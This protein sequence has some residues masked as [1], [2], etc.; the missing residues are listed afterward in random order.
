MS[1]SNKRVYTGTDNPI[2][3]QRMRGTAKQTYENTMASLQDT[4][5][6]YESSINENLNFEP[7]DIERFL[8]NDNNSYENKLTKDTNINWENITA[9]SLISFEGFKSEAY[10]DK[11]ISGNKDGFRV[12]YGSGT[13][14][15]NGK[16][17]KVKSGDTVTKEEAIADLNRRIGTEFGPRAAKQSG[18][19]WEGLSNNAKAALTSIVYNAGSLPKN[20]RVAIK[21]GNNAKIAE[22]I[23]ANGVGT[24]IAGRRTKEANLFLKPDSANSLVTRRNK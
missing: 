11:S 23:I 20:I 7:Q 19:S 1:E 18:E 3:I 9:N 8:S 5:E 16:V 15:I 22:A 4:I 6:Y 2:G 14:T 12:G 13:K 24:N 10:F 21:T 17:I